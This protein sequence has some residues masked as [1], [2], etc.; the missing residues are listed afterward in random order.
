MEYA[1]RGKVVIAADRINLELKESSSI[2]GDET[3]GELKK[4]YP[5][6]HI[7]FTNIGN[8]HSVGQVPLTWPRQVMALVELPTHLGVD[9][10]EIEKIFTQDVIQRAREIHKAMDQYGLGAYTHSQGPLPFR[11]DIAQ[12]IEN[13]DGLIEGSVD[14]DCIFMTNGASSAINMIMTA[15]I[16]DSTW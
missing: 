3:E 9:H 4:K 6:D 14:P 5:F 15:L 10:P 16:A 11:R 12:F 8:P 1:V 7:V 13:R 2:T